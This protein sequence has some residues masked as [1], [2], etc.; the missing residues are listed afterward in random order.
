MGKCKPETT[1]VYITLE[2]HYV[3][4][5]SAWEEMSG[6]AKR[7]RESLGGPAFVF[8]GV[9]GALQVLRMDKKF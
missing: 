9:P 1:Y 3:V 7:E 5:V 2:L 6:Y 8:S 4:C